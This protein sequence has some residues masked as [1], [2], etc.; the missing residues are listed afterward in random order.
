[1]SGT[2]PYRCG[3]LS[4]PT[5]V[6][7]ANAGP[8]QII[9]IDIDTTR[10]QFLQFRIRIG[11]YSST[12]STC[13]RVD[14]VDEGVVVDHSNDGGTTWQ[15][16][17]NIAYNSFTSPGF[18]AIE[19]PTGARS[20]ST[21]FRW[22]QPHNDGL[23]R[24]EWLLGDVFIGGNTSRYQTVLDDKFDP[25]DSGNWLFYPNSRLI[26]YCHSRAGNHTT[27]GNAVVFSGSSGDRFISTRDLSL[28][29]NSYVIFDLNIGCGSS[30]SS[31]SY[32]VQLQYSVNRGLSWSLVYSACRL[33]ASCSS[34]RT[35]TSF[36]A[37][38]F[39][40]W[41]RVIVFLP[42]AAITTQTRFRWYQSSYS[43]AFSW[44]I[45]NVFIGAACPNLCGGHGRCNSNLTCSCDDG[46]GGVDCQP[47]TG[48]LPTTFK[49]TFENDTLLQ[50]NWL[51]YE[52]GDVGTRCGII[53]SGKSLSFY[54]LGTR[55]AVTRDLNTT[56]AR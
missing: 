33:G 13:N 3:P 4:G 32:N 51:L 24:D 6:L 23:N 45:D 31:D 38:E 41:A 28:A 36:R 5:A 29:S 27:T 30:Y 22:W 34:Y 1:M 11:T 54:K 55:I 12:S 18:V 47:I 35:G 56:A 49:E 17:K 19:L 53:A 43:T 46:Y 20:P 48:S 50:Q 14:R 10:A 42:S 52:G 7:F 37:G 25:I 26:A 39:R 15:L 9:S 40:N 2:Q 16:L 8:R 21:R 44:A